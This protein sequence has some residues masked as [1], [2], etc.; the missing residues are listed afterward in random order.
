[1]R[2]SILGARVHF[3]EDHCERFLF[4][5][6]PSSPCGEKELLFKL[7]CNCELYNI[8]KYRSPLPPRLP[9]L[10]TTSYWLCREWPQGRFHS[11]LEGERRNMNF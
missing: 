7:V 6:P 1:M 2:M 8:L 5:D 9:R 10:R 4:R 11:L 3:A